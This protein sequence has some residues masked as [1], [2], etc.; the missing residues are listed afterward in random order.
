MIGFA[1]WSQPTWRGG[2]HGHKCSEGL[3]L[4]IQ[5]AITATQ[6][7]SVRG[8]Q[9]LLSVICGNKHH[10]EDRVAS[11]NWAWDSMATKQHGLIN[12]INDDV[13]GLVSLRRGLSPS[14]PPK[15]KERTITLKQIHQTIP[16]LA[17]NKIMFQSWVRAHSHRQKS[18]LVK[19]SSNQYN[20]E[21]SSF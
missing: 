20:R 9:R 15:V 6:E 17:V 11:D 7:K 16:F 5:S 18:Y 3:W 2:T 4:Q 19:S 10:H 13:L 12:E 14:S 21:D 8:Q 1:L